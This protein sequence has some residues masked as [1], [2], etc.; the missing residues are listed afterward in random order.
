MLVVILVLFSVIANGAG[1]RWTD[2]NQDP[3]K[4]TTETALKAMVPFGLP[5]GAVSEIARCFKEK[6]A[7][8]GE[9]KKGSGG[10]VMVYGS[11]TSPKTVKDVIYDWE[12]FTGLE[13]DDCASGEFLVRVVRV[14]NNYLLEKKPPVAQAPIAA[15]VTPAPS[16]PSPREIELISSVP[17]HTT[18]VV[19]YEVIDDKFL[20]SI[21]ERTNRNLTQKE[22]VAAR[23]AGMLRYYTGPGRVKITL[24]DMD[25]AAVGGSPV[26]LG[27]MTLDQNTYFPREISPHRTAVEIVPQRGRAELT[28]PRSLV[29]NSSWRTTE[30][31]GLPKNVTAVHTGSILHSCPSKS[32]RM[33]GD[34]PPEEW[35]KQVHELRWQWTLL[36][37]FVKKQ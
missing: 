22:I 21:G 33:C 31:I 1:N 14:C 34:G 24:H 27:R 36:Y 10:L 26:S 23:K 4:G 3:Y 6:R 9:V 37:F 17:S 5:Q 15:V 32:S 28:V 12:K 2:V 11:S 29:T 20:D 18:I 7:Q 35:H 19:V 16:T 30:L 25:W 8:K 13:T